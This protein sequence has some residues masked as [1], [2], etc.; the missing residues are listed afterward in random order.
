VP[1]YHADFDIL[2]ERGQVST[3]IPFEAPNPVN[4]YFDVL[5]DFSDGTDLKVTFRTSSRGHAR[6][7]DGASEDWCTSDSGVTHC[8]VHIE[9]LT[10]QT[11]G[12]WTALIDKR[13]DPPADVHIEIIWWTQPGLG[14]EN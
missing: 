6:I 7:L 5:I 1:E 2:L 14:E 4:H 10:G 9:T 3:S 8:V 13:S 12:E 11:P